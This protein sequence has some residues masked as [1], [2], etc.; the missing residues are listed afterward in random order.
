MTGVLPAGLLPH[1][2]QTYIVMTCVGLVVGMLGHV[3]RSR[4]LVLAG[5]LLVFAATV[6]FP[7]AVNV[8][9]DTPPAPAGPTPPP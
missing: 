1:D 7:L 6:L 2:V 9:H 4:W 3:A 8:T 5:I